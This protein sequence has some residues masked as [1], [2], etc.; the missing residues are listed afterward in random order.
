MALRPFSFTASVLPLF[1]GT[2]LAAFAGYNI[3]WFR[4]GVLVFAVVAVH[5]AANLLNDYYDFVRGVDQHVFPVSGAVVRGW[6]SGMQVRRVA[7]VLLVAGVGVAGGLIWVSDWKLLV[8]VLVGIGLALGYTR[9][10]LCLKYVGLGDP[11]VLL[12]FGI[13]PVLAAW[14]LQTGAFAWFPVWWSLPPGLLAVAILHANNW[15]D[16]LHDAEKGCKTL[17]VRLGSR[18]CRLYW[19][20]LLLM[21]MATVVMAVCAGR[22]LYKGE[23]APIWTLG[24]LVLVPEMI[25]MVRVDWSRHPDA[26]A[27]L[28]ARAARLHSAFT[29]LLSAGFLLSW[30]LS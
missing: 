15:R 4:F 23:H 1:L 5:A 30:W 21:S 20:G 11:T 18:G 27:V 16:R 12:G 24:T 25:R 3:T 22:I 7:F 9:E 10:G 13:L 6:L 2:V 28:D 14:V 17:A 29:F 19:Q 8:L 26:L